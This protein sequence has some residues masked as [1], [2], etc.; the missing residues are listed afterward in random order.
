MLPPSATCS[1]EIRGPFWKQENVLLPGYYLFTLQVKRGSDVV[2]VDRRY[3][4]FDL[5]RKALEVIYPG[6]FIPCLP[7]KD[8]FISLSHEDSDTLKQRKVGIK[9]FV[10]SVMSH[11]VL[12]AEPIV[13][14]FLETRP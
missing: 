7:P 11:E 12:S 13:I 10:T 1:I 4:D 9:Q 5:L 3:S 8:K 14:D 2:T 6:I